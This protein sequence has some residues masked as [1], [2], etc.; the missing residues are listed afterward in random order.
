MTEA[1]KVDAG[2]NLGEAGVSL[3]DQLLQR[4][5][6]GT[7]WVAADQVATQLV[8]IAVYI[9]LAHLLAPHAFG[10]MAM[11]AVFVGFVTLLGQL[12]VE[13]ALVQARRLDAGAVSAAFWGAVAVNCVLVAVFAAAAPAIA[14]IYD[15]PSLQPVVLTLAA[16]PL[17]GVI[18]SVPRGLLA[19]ELRFRP[20]FVADITAI[21]VSAAVT[22]GAAAGGLGAMSLAFGLLA[23]SAVQAIVL[24]P[25]MNVRA[26]TTRP[27]W[28]GAR[29]LTAYTSNLIGFN[30]INY[31]SRNADNLLI[32]RF[33]GAVS[34]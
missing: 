16:A 31:W 19:R 26:L 2:G 25:A 10:V 22:I 5:V 24:L 4:S 23:R 21:A 8:Q 20:V 15:Q 17:L 32:G 6:H 7:L 29:G 27:H 33:L 28:Q 13:S 1:T 14:D 18:A 34:L 11:A 9:V 12:G 30:V 3:E